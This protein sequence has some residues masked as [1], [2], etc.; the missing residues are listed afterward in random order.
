MGLGRRY[1]PTLDL[2]DAG[3]IRAVTEGRL[4]LQ[5][6]QWVR[7]GN[8]ARSRYVAISDAGVINAVHPQPRQYE[9]FLDR[10]KA[11][12]PLVRKIDVNQM[13]LPL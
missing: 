12:K 13:D 5:R 10:C 3:V 4:V 7:C 2:W 11:Y 9:M 6:G 8:Q 1:L